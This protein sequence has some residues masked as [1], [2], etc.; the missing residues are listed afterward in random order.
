[1]TTGLTVTRETASSE[2]MGAELV[3]ARRNSGLPAGELSSGC[4]TRVRPAGLRAACGLEWRKLFST[5]ANLGVLI[6]IAVSVVGAAALIVVYREGLAAN[7]APWWKMNTSIVATL[8]AFFLTFLA[9][10]VVT[11]EWATRS[12]MVTF[13]LIPRRSLVLVA[14]G[15]VVTAIT[16][17][18]YLLTMLAVV[19]SYGVGCYLDGNTPVWDMPLEFIAG[20][21]ADFL[22]TVW[23]GFALALMIQNTAIALVVYLF[24]PTLLS[25]FGAINA[26]LARI[27]EYC[28]LSQTTAQTLLSMGTAPIDSQA[29]IRLATAVTIWLVIPGAIGIWRSLRREVN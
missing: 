7:P 18:T 6:L 23:A 3:N 22:L 11:G 25:S 28:D 21:G 1:M 12:A 20:F 16:A 4:Y 26:S 9:V 2:T 13:A 15:A 8:P 10:T 24:G 29:W 14:K 27:V 5:R 19:A 17:L